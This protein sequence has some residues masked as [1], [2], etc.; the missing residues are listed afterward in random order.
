[1]VDT[2]IK[3]CMEMRDIDWRVR[4]RSLV[5]VRYSQVA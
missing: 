3:I 1:M 2:Y 5:L 4:S